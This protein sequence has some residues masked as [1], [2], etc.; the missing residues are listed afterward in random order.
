M[1]L[2]FIVL[3]LFFIHGCG[4]NSELQPVSPTPT[5]E[6][7]SQNTQLK[8]CSHKPRSSDSLN[9]LVLKGYRTALDC[10]LTAD[11]IAA[12]P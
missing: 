10:D 12:M 6:T 1:K 9:D 3:I 11:E 8:K 4:K 2:R 7:Q 5:G